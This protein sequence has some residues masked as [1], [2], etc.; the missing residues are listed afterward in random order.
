[1]NA[2]TSRQRVLLWREVRAMMIKITRRMVLLSR[3]DLMFK[4]ITSCYLIIM[5]YSLVLCYVFYY[6]VPDMTNN[7][8]RGFI[9][10]AYTRDGQILYTPQHGLSCVGDTKIRE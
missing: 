2:R 6:T 5:L 10:G 1:M 8:I 4:S 7:D 9:G 3:K